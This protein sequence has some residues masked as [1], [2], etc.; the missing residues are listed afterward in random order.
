MKISHWGPALLGI[1]VLAISAAL[2]GGLLTFRREPAE[3]ITAK[4]EKPVHVEVQTV[5]PLDVPVII[6][7]YG[8]VKA[9]RTLAITPEVA[10]RIVAIHPDLK[11]GGR[12]GEGEVLFEID[13]RPYAAHVADA[14]AQIQRQESALLR[15]K[16]E[17]QHAAEDLKDL[18]RKAELAASAHARASTLHEQGIGSQ[19]SVDDAEQ[20]LVS[21]RNAHDQLARDLDLY[22]IRIGEAESDL[23]SAQARLKL[24]QVDLEHTR[25]TAPFPAR[26]KEE[27][28]E[29][30]AIVSVGSP[31][32]TL[33][34]DSVLEI[35]VP[36][37]SRDARKWLKFQSR[38]DAPADAWFG[39][40]APV[41]CTIRWTE[42]EAGQH[43]EGTLDRVERYDEASRTL[44]VVVRIAGAQRQS[45]AD[46]FPLVDG[47]F[48]SVQ[49]PGRDMKGVFGLPSHAVSF[50][51]TV[52]VADGDRLKTV[53]VTVAR[54]E[55]DFTYVAGG[56]QPGDRVV[57]T[58]LVNPLDRTLL[59]VTE[60]ADGATE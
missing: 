5:Q 48:C 4:D 34:D 15:L 11:A 17:Q 10:G 23:L 24:A 22:P 40:L 38:D 59:S 44:T 6:S 7:G 57:V 2:M 26:V 55:D 43:W 58:R 53:P 31:L 52:F 50:E 46:H 56:L 42:G 39:D 12:I 32:A 36:L 21:A 29:L 14:E 3:A 35:A 13:P 1:V 60:A 51:D 41:P 30:G 45:P 20:A 37:N 18:A 54:I 33:A 9:L 27:Q 25:V 16:T 28:V 19:A 8:E 49:I 47:M